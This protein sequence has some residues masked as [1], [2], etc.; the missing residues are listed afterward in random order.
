MKILVLNAEEMKQ[1]MPMR[2]LIDADKAALLAYSN[3]DST[4]PLRTHMAVPEHAG[5]CLFMPGYVA[6][7]AALGSK[8]LSVYPENP[9]RGLPSI[10]SLMILFDPQNGAIN[11]LMDG[12]ELTKMRTGALA[13]AATDLL[14]KRSAA[15]FTLIGTGGQAAEQLAAVLAVRP[16]KKVYVYDISKRR[17]DDFATAMK[18][19]FGN[20]Y[21]AEIVVADAL[22][23][24][25]K[26][27]D[28]IT[29][30]TTAKAPVFDGAWVKAGVHVNA[31]GAYTPDMQE[32]PEPLLQ[33]SDLIYFD[34]KD[35]V[36]NESG[37]IIK[38][39]RNGSF[40]PQRDLTGE[41]GDLI[42]GRT[43]G[44]NDDAQI[45]LFESTGTAV[46][47][48]VVA[49]KLYEAARACGD[50]GSWIEL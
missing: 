46:L 14:A 41:L 5:M 21:A 40:D 31:I 37:D 10:S 3:G 36:I 23:E 30:V 43:P 34:T 9:A 32:L 13:G 33:K 17:A 24:A 18:A 38:P 48:V 19:R 50:I 11:C 15:V 22:E 39:M 26:A 1:L 42:A 6:T 27:A 8:V 45:T 7:E 12:S 28:V 49:R 4:I 2:A 25:V 16:I 20:D 29:T 47:D 35:G 44:R